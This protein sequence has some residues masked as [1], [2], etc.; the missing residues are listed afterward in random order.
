RPVAAAAGEAKLQAARDRGAVDVVDYDR[1]DLKARLR[2]LL[3]AGADVVVD[4][5]GGPYSEPTLR[6]VRWGGRYV[7]VGFAAG[8]IPRIPLN[9]VLLKGVWLTGFENRTVLQHSPSAAAHRAEVLQLLLDGAVVP[10]V[11]SV[12]GLDDVVPALRELADRRAVGKVVVAV[13]D[14]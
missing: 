5:V 12:H 7:V 14:S 8:E 9:L 4:P 13:S 1:E 10:H 6:N 2:E 3:P 11:S